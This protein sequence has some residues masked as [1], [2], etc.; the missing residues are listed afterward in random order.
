MNT[1]DLNQLRD[2]LEDP[3]VW[4]TDKLSEQ[5]VKCGAYCGLTLM[6]W[7]VCNFVIKSCCK[8]Q[9]N[10]KDDEYTVEQALVSVTVKDDKA[11]ET[12]SS[13]DLSSSV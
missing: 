5:T 8:I 10:C 4:F 1:F 6:V 3:F 9:R 2:T 7:S 12:H 11:N 13:S